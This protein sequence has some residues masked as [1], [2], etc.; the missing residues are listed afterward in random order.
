LSLEA[1]FAARRKAHRRRWQKLYVIAAR[2]MELAA[3]E[4]VE[5]DIGE[6]YLD[7]RGFPTREIKCRSTVPN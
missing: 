2:N 6:W 5:M 4:R 1:E 7:E 3:L